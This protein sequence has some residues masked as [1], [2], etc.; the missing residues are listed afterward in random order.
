MS[1]SSEVLADA[2]L[3]YWRM[4]ETSGT[5]M[6]DSSGNARHGSY[7]NAPV[8]GATSLLVSDPTNP[9]V[10][11]VASSSD[12][13]VVTDDNSLDGLTAFTVE[14]IIKP[15]T[16]SGFPMIAARDDS[17]GGRS[18]QFRLN[19]S[20]GK[21]EFLRIP[22]TTV[23]AASSSSIA[24][25]N[26][27]HVA[28][29]YNGTDIRLYINGV[30]DGTPAACTGS[31]GTA[32][33]DLRI[34]ARR[35]N[36]NGVTTDYFN[37][38]LDEV[39]VY[40]TALSATRLAAH[41]AAATTPPVAGSLVQAFSTFGVSLAGAFTAPTGV[42]GVLGETFPAFGSDFVGTAT[43]PES[44]TVRI[45]IPAGTVASTLTDFVTRVD[46]SH[47]PSDWW[48]GVSDGGTNI[49]VKSGSEDVPVHVAEVDTVNRTG[50]LFFKATLTTGD[51]DF[52][53]EARVGATALTPGE[54][55]GK[56]AVWS[57]YESVIFPGLSLENH[58]DGS[59]VTSVGTTPLITPLDR[60][61]ISW[62]NTIAHDGVAVD[63]DYYYVI[64]SKDYITKYDRDW[65]QVAQMS[66]GG[67]IA[68]FSAATLSGGVVLDGKLWVQASGGSTIKIIA[69]NTSDFTLAE[70]Y[71]ISASGWAPADVTTDG[72][73]FYTTGYNVGPNVDTT[74][75]KWNP[76]WTINSLITMSAAIA[77]KQGIELHGGYFWIGGSNDLW[78][79]NLDG[80]GVVRALSSGQLTSEVQGLSSRGDF[81]FG[82]LQSGEGNRVY[83]F[84]ASSLDAAPFDGRRYLKQTGL[85]KF[86]AWTMGLTARLWHGVT[87]S[88]G[89][90]KFF[91]SYGTNDGG[92]SNNQYLYAS[93]S[94]DRYTIGNSTDGVLIDPTV[95]PAR[96]DQYRF[97]VTH[98]TTV[99]R[100]LYRDGAARAI[101]SGVAQ[102]PGG[103]GDTFFIGAE[104]T[105][106]SA[107]M[108]GS[109]TR[110]Y[111]REGILSPGWLAA[112]T[113]SWESPGDFYT[114]EVV[115]EPVSALD[116]DFP[117]FGFSGSGDVAFASNLD[118]AFAPFEVEAFGE[119]DAIAG[120][121]GSAFGS[122][123]VA[124]AGAT[125]GVIGTDTRN[126][127][128][129]MVMDGYA[130]V[131]TEVSPS[132]LPRP[133]EYD[134]DATWALA[135]PT[136][137]DGRPT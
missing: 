49:R 85:A 115:T 113:L 45:R 93:S 124:L 57:D 130:E 34:A 55:I 104:N 73:Y 100:R 14:A 128:E 3:G 62:G 47:M 120:L 37:G 1:Y 116:V 87:G 67:T 72:T 127:L 40:N 101:D 97:H 129:G 126:Q 29:V 136:L 98:D 22:G 108:Y 35:S 31:I 24:A 42:V 137:V 56:Y 17:T 92:G 5:V 88:S 77:D 74:I 105:D 58:A 70:V 46:L 133:D 125:S 53:I 78:R 68:G 52:N 19:G 32:T 15:T 41:Y 43:D 81:L 75:Q 80:S 10:E 94:T 79:V 13:C 23:T 16:V 114:V 134:M 107:P 39:A 20:T 12:Y 36:S 26:T 54:P 61:P 95:V 132:F 110:I 103:A 38:V 9:A 2:P 63:D 8:L 27:Y 135:E 60:S 59:T 131:D 96:W 83:E 66:N 69:I 4:S 50:S 122:F 71:D 121:L 30:L 118:F 76:D 7:V 18:F 11:F 109:L 82:L 51:N 99:E 89:T 21:L 65:N 123:G 86:S 6:S 117:S 102:R 64:G 90:T 33:T 106:N 48:A 111:L 25:G 112:E 84:G 28:A 44:P 91:G 119:T